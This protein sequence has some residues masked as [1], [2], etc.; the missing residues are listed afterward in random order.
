[1]LEFCLHIYLELRCN[2][3]V[4]LL[5]QRLTLMDFFSPRPWFVSGFGIVSFKGPVA[6]IFKTNY[7]CAAKL[8]DIPSKVPVCGNWCFF[9]MTEDILFPISQWCLFESW[10]IKILIVFRTLYWRKR[11]KNA[12]NKYNKFLNC[13]ILFASLKFCDY[14]N[15]CIQL[16]NLLK[17]NDY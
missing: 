5:S 4:F 15:T 9:G 11:L 13:R 16:N 17:L 2:F 14:S 7:F 12:F 1:M 10:R 8:C 6:A 3:N